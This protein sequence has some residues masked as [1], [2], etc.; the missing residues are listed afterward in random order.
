[1]V[2]VIHRYATLKKNIDKWV[3]TGH[4]HLFSCLLRYFLK[5]GLPPLICEFKGVTGFCVV[6]DYPPLGGEYFS[7]RAIGPKLSLVIAE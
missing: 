3:S 1:M 5:C 6:R 7:S 2:V 4:C